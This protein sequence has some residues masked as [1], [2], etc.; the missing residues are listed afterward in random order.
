[1]TSIVFCII[2]L[3]V[4]RV[5]IKEEKTMGEIKPYEY[6]KLVVGIM[7]TDSL[8]YERAIERLCGVYAGLDCVSEEYSFSGFSRFYDSEMNGE[9]MKRFVSFE[10]TVDPS[11]LS[12]IKILTN[13]IER[14]FSCEGE[15]RV[16]I[17]PCMLSH[18]KFVMA[19]TKSASFRVPLSRGIYADL[20]LVYSRGGWVDF[21]WTYFD[22]KSDRV[23]S[24]L[25]RVRDIYLRQR[26]TV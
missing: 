18:G 13:D 23:K 9:V 15:R 5:T 20:S 19:T 26:K 6:E 25:K 1:M 12:E 10:R 11:L 21:F 17:D 2:I 3:T 4:N 8:L 7:Y 14:E 22:V 16:N 24:F